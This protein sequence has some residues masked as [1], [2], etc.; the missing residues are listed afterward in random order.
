MIVRSWQ[1]FAPRENADPY[2]QHLRAD[3]FPVLDDIPG[4]QGIQ[5]L[6]RDANDEVEFVVLTT[7]ASMD[8]IRR[9]TGDQ[10]EVAVVAAVARA[11]LS[12]WDEE[13]HHYDVAYA[14]RARSG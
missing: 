5:I 11:L 7:W 13:V 10:P 4:Y 9:F 8:A 6:R 14:A 2:V 12:H 1:G 3:V